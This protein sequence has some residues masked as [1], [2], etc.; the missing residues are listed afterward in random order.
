L[1][2]IREFEATQEMELVGTVLK[3]ED[4]N[5]VIADAKLKDVAP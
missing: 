5:R 4:P 3:I 1:R 2:K